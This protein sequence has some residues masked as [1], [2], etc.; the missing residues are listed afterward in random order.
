[1]N[2][3]PPPEQ[4][5]QEEENPNPVTGNVAATTPTV[6]IYLND[7]TIFAASDY[8]LA[9]GQLRYYVNYG[10]E[11]SVDMGEV[12]LQRTVNENAKRG[13]RFSLKPNPDSANPAPSSNDYRPRYE[14]RP[15]NP[16]ANGDP[17]S[18][19]SNQNDNKQTA[20]AINPAP[21]PQPEPRMETT[22]Q[23]ALSHS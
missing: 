11:N 17:S 12:D 2:Q 8:W 6:L 22:S 23:P 7:G 16:N 14:N 9:D 21:S 3:A 19:T 15:R 4:G 1:M 18:T 10:G 13:V 5:F 20:P